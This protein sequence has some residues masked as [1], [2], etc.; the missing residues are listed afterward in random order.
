[1]NRLLRPVAPLAFA[2]ALGGCS[3]GGLLGGGTKAPT[4]LLTLLPLALCASAR[5]ESLP[6]APG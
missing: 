2:V 4:T 6:R 3:L 5:A 1:M